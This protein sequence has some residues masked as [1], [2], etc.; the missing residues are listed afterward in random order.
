MAAHT[1]PIPVKEVASLIGHEGPVMSVRFNRKW[2]CV[3]LGFYDARVLFLYLCGGHTD[4]VCADDGHYCLTASGDRQVRL[5][6]PSKGLLVK[7]YQ[8]HGREVNDALAYV[9]FWHPDA[10]S[11]PSDHCCA[12]LG[13][14]TIT[15]S[16]PA[17]KTSRCFFGMS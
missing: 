5:W 2:R 7:T 10:S 1:I 3:L 17:G 14:L 11:M 4:K 12:P 13:R 16:C 8:G 9:P 15:G 6:N